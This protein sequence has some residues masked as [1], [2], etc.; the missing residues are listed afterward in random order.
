VAD[1]GGPGKAGQLDLEHLTVHSSLKAGRVYECNGFE[2]STRV[3]YA[4]SLVT[5]KVTV[6]HLREAQLPSCMK[7][8]WQSPDHGQIRD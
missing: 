2:F 7:D 6:L 1:G 3:L 4:D 8:A 5:D